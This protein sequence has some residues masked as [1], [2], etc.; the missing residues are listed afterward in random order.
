[1]KGEIS[2]NMI[3]VLVLAT[4]A[5]TLAIAMVTNHSSN[6]EDGF[7]ETA[8]T[9]SG[10]VDNASCKRDCRKNNPSQG[11]GYYTCLQTNGCS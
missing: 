6:A 4:V 11:P 1:M 2:T 3:L 7:N 5:A 8:E 10:Q 9:T